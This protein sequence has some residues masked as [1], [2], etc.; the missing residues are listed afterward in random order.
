MQHNRWFCDEFGN[1]II[2]MQNKFPVEYN[3]T[4]SHRLRSGQ[5]MQ[6]A[7]AY[8]Y[9]MLSVREHFNVTNEFAALDTDEDGLWTWIP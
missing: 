8:M 1:F 7:F 5:D 6:Y 3:V 9:Y 2:R 4:S